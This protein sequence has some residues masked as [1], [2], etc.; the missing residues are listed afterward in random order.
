MQAGNISHPQDYGQKYRKTTMDL[1]MMH[2]LNK[3]FFNFLTYEDYD[4]WTTSH[5]RSHRDQTDRFVQFRSPG[6]PSLATQ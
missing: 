2:C 6:Q 1:D 3:S 4:E 5:R